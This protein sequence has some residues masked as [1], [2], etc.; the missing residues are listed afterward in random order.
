M[1]PT[2]ETQ[3]VFALDGSTITYIDPALIST[4]KVSFNLLGQS[5]S[6]LAVALNENFISLAQ[7]FYGETPPLNPLDGQQWLNKSD[8][9]MYVWRNNNWVQ[10]TPDVSFDCFLYIKYAIQVNEFII[11]DTVFNFTINNIQLYNQ[12]M[13]VIKFI[14]DPFDSKKIILKE[15]NVTTLYIMVFHP[16]DRIA[17]PFLNK[18]TEMY[19]TSGQTQYDIENFLSGTDINTLS[20]SL[21]EVMLKNNEFS[22]VNNI[23]TLDGMVYRIKENDKITIWRNGGSLS[24]YYS[25][26]HIETDTRVDSLRIPKFFKS[27]LHIELVDVDAKTVINPINL[28]EEATYYHFDFLDNKLVSSTV[29]I[30]II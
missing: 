10:T 23:L 19:T 20:V 16:K 5:T 26:L 12:D 9:L 22:I 15:T 7:S 6:D 4:D 29:K 25:T 11:D 14:I 13:K 8:D 21:N 28:D 3:P 27:L 24:A 18:K 1:S 17:N 2:N 30:R